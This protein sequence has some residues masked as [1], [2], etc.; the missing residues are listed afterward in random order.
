MADYEKARYIKVTNVATYDDAKFSIKDL[1]VFGTTDRMSRSIVKD[2][3][4][5][6]NPEDRREANLLWDAVPGA[7]GYVVRYGI[8]PDKLYNSYIVYDKTTLY[9]HSLNT[10]PE[11]FFEVEAFD[12]GLDYYREPYLATLG[13]GAEIQVAK[14]TRNFAPGA[15]RQNQ[16][17]KI[18]MLKEGVTEYVF[19]DIDP[20]MWVLNHSYGPVLWSGELTGKELISDKKNPK[21]TVE[22]FLTRLGK[23]TEVTG[24]LMM[25][26]I[27]GKEKG[28]IVVTIENK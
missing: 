28:K 20:G 26:I 7:D 21:P 17:T 23:G 1:R 12:S 2:V 19:E 16:D 5:V 24:N 6:R 15:Y 10:A 18:L 11:Y 22:A 13:N 8:E 27:P 9:M 4:V 14:R 3:K 25:K